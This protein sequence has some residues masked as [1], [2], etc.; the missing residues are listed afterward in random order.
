MFSN[1]AEYALRAVVHL[2]IS[3]GKACTSQDI[4]AMTKVP[5]GYL[6]K[7]LQDL[8]KAGVVHSQRGPNGGFV[9]ARS[10]D[11]LTVLEVIN[12]VDPIRRILKCPLDIPSHGPKL[13]R[14]HKRLDDSIATVE[15]TLGESTIAAMMEP[16]TAGSR[17]LF[18]T[19]KG[20]SSANG[21]RTKK[22]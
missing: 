4:A 15:A 16:S 13:C 9:L 2:A 7:I 5:G 11:E 6:S 14:L 1:T 21:Q 17:C 19:I 20:K 22:R 18:P 3:Q 10:P 12:A 8:G